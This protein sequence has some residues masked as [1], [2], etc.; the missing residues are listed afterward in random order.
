MWS[1]MV[2]EITYFKIDQ[3]ADYLYKVGE[4]P[5]ADEVSERIKAALAVSP[6][7]IELSQGQ[8]ANKNK[9]L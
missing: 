9:P 8:D 7:E 1:G 5:L 6:V 4:F 3:V 2:R